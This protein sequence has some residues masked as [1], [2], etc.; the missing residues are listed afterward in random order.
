M[1]PELL[2]YSSSSSLLSKISAEIQSVHR[3]DS[4]VAEKQSAT[5]APRSVPLLWDDWDDAKGEVCGHFCDD[6]DDDEVDL[7]EMGL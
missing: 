5:K 1:L 4:V 2:R 7:S 6:D 3:T